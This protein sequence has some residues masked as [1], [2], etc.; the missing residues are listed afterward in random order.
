MNLYPNIKI[1]FFAIA[2]L[3]W[4]K[5]ARG[6]IDYYIPDVFEYNILL[7]IIAL[8]IF[9]MD[10]GVIDEI[11]NKKIDFSPYYINNRNNRNPINTT[12]K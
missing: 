5:G 4:F 10:D 12:K 7:V 8:V 1:L 11:S 3:L 9:Y 6:I 2:S